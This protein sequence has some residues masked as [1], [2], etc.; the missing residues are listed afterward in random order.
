MTNDSSAFRDP[1]MWTINGN[2][3]ISIYE[4]FNIPFSFILSKENKKFDQP[5]YQ[6]FG[7]SPSY[8]GLTAHVGYR[9]LNFSRYTLSGITFLGGGIEYAPKNS[10]FKLKGFYGRFARAQQFIADNMY[11]PQAIFVMPKYER[12][13]Y[14]T[15]LTI[16]KKDHLFDLILFK[17]SDD[18]LSAVIPDSL[19]V[20]PEENFVIGFNSKNKLLKD[21]IFEL[22]YSLSAL[23][24]DVRQSEIHQETYSYANNLGFLFTPRS[25]SQFNSVI[26]A[27]INFTPGKVNVGFKYLRI[28]PEYKSLGTSFINNDVQEFTGNIATTLNKNKMSIVGNIGV[29]NNNLN[30]K[31]LVTNKRFISALNYT[32]LINKNLNLVASLSN[33]NTNAMPVQIYLVDSIKYSQVTS[34]AS[35]NLMENFG[36]SI[37]QHGISGMFCYQNG[38]TLNQTG[39]SISDVTNTFINTYITYRLN[40]VKTGLCFITTINYSNY[41]SD[42]IDTK[43]FG[44]SIGVTKSLL[45]QKINTGINMTFMN[46]FGSDSNITQILNM[47]LFARYKINKYNSLNISI[48][49]LNRTMNKISSFHAQVNFSYNLIF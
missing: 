44:P 37:I 17:S 34:N 41:I 5:S 25:S 38:N 15:M 13:G 20:Y 40:Y 26:D 3:N 23:S 9:N 45:K 48:N 1:F 18:E 6:Q 4:I 31:Q 19:S 8:K 49:G 21:L 29:Q 27:S 36:D 39:E 42:I 22:N 30:K 16:G 43:S 7:I 11:N 2:F 32:W 46:S 28:D 14:G 35:L 47:R 10:F 33:Y 24:T 12:W